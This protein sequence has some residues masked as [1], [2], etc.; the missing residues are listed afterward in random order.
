MEGGAGVIT[1]APIPTDAPAPPSIPT[2]HTQCSSP[3]LHSYTPTPNAPAPPSFHTQYPSLSLHSHP[4]PQPLPHFTPKAPSFTPNA[5]APPSIPTAGCR[6]GGR[7]W[8]LGVGCRNGGRGLLTIAWGL[9]ELLS[10]P[11]HPFFTGT[12]VLVFGKT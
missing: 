1:P 4:M 11:M 12:C 3:S 2:P 10:G 8:G 6:N 5:P 9:V 7:G